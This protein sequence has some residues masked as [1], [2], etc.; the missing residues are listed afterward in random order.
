MLL[1]KKLKGVIISSETRTER[2]INLMF[3]YCL[4]RGRIKDIFGT[5]DNF[6]KALGIG[7]V[8]LSQRLNNRLE[9]S[10]KEI[11]LSCELLH[12]NKAEIQYYF[13][14]DKVKKNEQK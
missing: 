8:S 12:I 13:F 5:Q 6:A 11:A 7:H 4:L 9:F 10:Q 14:R 2:G 3:D 1:T